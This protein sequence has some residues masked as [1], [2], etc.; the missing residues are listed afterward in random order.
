LAGI[1]EVLWQM[2]KYCSFYIKV[3]K[4]SKGIGLEHLLELAV[5]VCIKQ[6]CE[7]L[8]AFYSQIIK[9]TAF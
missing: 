8:L 6:F 3:V 1:P 5:A 4:A 2:E 7:L 9:F